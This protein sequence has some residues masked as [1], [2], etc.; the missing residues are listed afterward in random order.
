MSAIDHTAVCRVLAP[1]KTKRDR[2]SKSNPMAH[3]IIFRFSQCKN[4]ANRCTVQVVCCT[5][6]ELLVVLTEV[7]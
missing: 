2:V 1:Q 7:I 3:V 6:K 5:F 4:S